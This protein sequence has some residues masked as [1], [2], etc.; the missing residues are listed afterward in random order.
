MVGQSFRA[1]DFP[2][3]NKDYGGAPDVDYFWVLM[4]GKRKVVL[5]P[6]KV[7]E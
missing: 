6:D 4:D 2:A 1:G 5:S 7:D 3:R